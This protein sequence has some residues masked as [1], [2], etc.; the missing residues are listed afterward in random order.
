MTET[1][2]VEKQLQA[3]R[4]LMGDSFVDNN[5]EWIDR[6]IAELNARAPQPEGGK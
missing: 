1:S 5:R 2:Q 3:L 6:A 4:A